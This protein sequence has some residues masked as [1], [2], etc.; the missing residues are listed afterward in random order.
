MGSLLL[1]QSL[2]VKK[3]Q[4]DFSSTNVYTLGSPITGSKD[5]LNL[6][7]GVCEKIYDSKLT[8]TLKKIV[9]NFFWLKSLFPYSGTPV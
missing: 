5:L 9:T 8:S 4:I 1:L 7:K 3:C 2:V 6:V